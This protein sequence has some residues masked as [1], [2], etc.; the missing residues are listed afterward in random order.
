[1][2][3]ELIPD[4]GEVDGIQLDIRTA[5]TVE[6]HDAKLAEVL[7]D[8]VR[9][10]ALMTPLNAYNSFAREYGC[11]ITCDH[12]FWER[13]FALRDGTILRFR[14]VATTWLSS[15]RDHQETHRMLY[16]GAQRMILRQQRVLYAIVGHHPPSWTIENDKADQ[17]FS[18]LTFLQVFGHKHE[19]WLTAI[20]NSVRVIAGAVHPSRQES[21]WLPRY[22]AIA[23]SAAPDGKRVDLRI[24]P[25]RWSD[26]EIM[27]IGDFN[28]EGHDFR[29]FE[30]A[31][32]VW[33]G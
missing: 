21:K 29:D 2:D 25:R 15:S 24:Y 31:V 3:R 22:S 7:R 26:E 10:S 4:N 33:R 27:F 28:S 18:R 9:G 1:V 12:P 8:G 20:G 32:D 6:E 5:R 30:V 19:Q 11:E 13:D 16:G 14:G 17:V 23:V